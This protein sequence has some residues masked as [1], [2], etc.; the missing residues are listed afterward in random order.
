MA[1]K[2]L[3]KVVGENG[4]SAYEIWLDNGNTGTEQDFLESLKGE[5][6][7][8]SAYALKADIPTDYIT[9]QELEEA[10]TNSIG[11]ALGGDY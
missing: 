8:L 1:I 3:G 10:I 4:K 11:V 2:N 6:Q 9:E 7:D 5:T